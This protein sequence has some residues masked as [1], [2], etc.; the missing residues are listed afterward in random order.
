M[1]ESKIKEPTIEESEQ[2]DNFMDHLGESA[3][4]KASLAEFLGIDDSDDEVLWRKHWIGMPEF[5]QENNESYKK[6]YVHFRNEED[7]QEF[8]KL[9]DQKMTEKTKSI[10][11]P[12]ADFGKNSLCRWIEEDSDDES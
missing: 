1:A 3:K 6:I 5:V 12:A 2:Y 9:V 10:W 7:Y 11:Y 4:N 8:A